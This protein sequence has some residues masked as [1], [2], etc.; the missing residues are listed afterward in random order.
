[1]N[2][3]L[4]AIDMDGT[5]LTRDK[6]IS[7]ENIK[8]LRRAHDEGVIIAI[9]TGRL[10]A[11]VKAYI[12]QIGF[13]PFLLGC[14]G[15]F[16]RDDRNNLIYRKTLEYDSSM[17]IVDVANKYNIYY[18]YFSDNIVFTSNFNSK[19][20]T[21][22]EWNETVRD[23][24][25]IKIVELKNDDDLKS[26]FQKG[27][28][29]FILNDDDLNEIIKIRKDLSKDN[30]INVTSSLPNNIEVIDKQVDKGNALKF[31]CNHLNIDKKNV[32]AIGDNENDLEMI[33][34]AGLGVA[35]GNAMDLIKE[36][37]DYITKTNEDDGVAYAI[38]KFA[39]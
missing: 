31:L 13:R 20:Q 5:L 24:L 9:C 28:L 4:I 22:D 7:E 1:M 6:R 16:I 35:M 34:F 21:Y 26:V 37:A 12:E 30:N 3:K 27:V 25:K 8:A 29:K 15:A 39:L 32:I 10:Y 14:N 23:D 2:Y 17:Y 19:F 36:N 18:Q 33:R 38:N 11:F